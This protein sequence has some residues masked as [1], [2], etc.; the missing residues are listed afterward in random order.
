MFLHLKISK[1]GFDW[2]PLAD[3]YGGEGLPYSSYSASKTSSR[4]STV[5]KWFFWASIGETS[6]PGGMPQHVV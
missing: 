3:E 2:F 6:R 1:P 5:L 4:D